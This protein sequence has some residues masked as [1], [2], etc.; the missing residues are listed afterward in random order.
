MEALRTYWQGLAPRERRFLGGGAVALVLI[1]GY[2]L[3]W[4]PYREAVAGLREDVAAQ[5]EQ[6]AWMHQAAAQVERLRAE[7]PE[8]GDTGRGSLLSRVDRTARGQGLGEA[9]Q[10]VRPDG[11]GRV[12]VW[13]EAAAFDRM[14]RWLGE[15]ER[16]GGVRVAEL[17]V[18]RGDAPGRVGARIVLEAQ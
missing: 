9:V 3:V 10:R 5:R 6:L 16:R 17:V 13:L 8:N 18:N 2:V 4:S 11:N 12:R 1:L 7:R 15:L 14:V